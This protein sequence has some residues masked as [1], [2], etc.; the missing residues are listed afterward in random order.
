MARSAF[1]LAA[2]APFVALACFSSSTT[3]PGNDAAVTAPT[4][5]AATPDDATTS[6]EAAP[7]QEAAAAD[8]AAP[9][10]ATPDA[11]VLEAAAPD[12]A[13][14]AA[15]APSLTITATGL[16]GPEPGVVVVFGDSNGAPIATATTDATGRVTQPLTLDAM[17]ITQAAV[18]FGI[19]GLT[20]LEVVTFVGVEAGDTLTAIDTTVVPQFQASITPPPSPP[21]TPDGYA[22]YAGEC[23]AS[24]GLI[25]LG[26]GC[27]GQGTFPVLALSEYTTPLA[28][29][30]DK[31]DP[32]STDGGTASIM[33]AG[34]WFTNFGTQTISATGLTSAQFGYVTFSE[35][36][37]GVPYY[38]PATSS[39]GFAYG[40]DGGLSQATFD[41]HPG[42]P[43]FVQSEFGVQGPVAQS[44]AVATRGPAPTTATPSG[45]ASFD[46]SQLLPVI[47]TAQLSPSGGLTVTWT[48]GTPGSPDAGVDAGV[49]AGAPGIAGTF[50]QVNGTYA[51][52]GGVQAISWVFVAPPSA[53]TVSAPMLPAA[54]SPWTLPSTGS[55]T[56]DSYSPTIISVASNLL[57]GYPA[58]RQSSHLLGPA[59]LRN[60]A[61]GPTAVTPL[62][63]DG[64]LAA[65]VY[66]PSQVVP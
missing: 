41:T 34:P 9:E 51:T 19:P 25:S 58:L 52:E 57:P 28:F 37:G 32:L 40:A 24:P 4:P 29:A 53:T 63:F 48:P 33:M 61:G 18:L 47:P 49:D 1:A 5:E 23:S 13:V 6:P 15:P 22:I 59:L 45:S 44:T 17:T 56:F 62:P 55:G 3:P 35:V 12:V 54:A 20:P 39:S 10:A 66:I 11:T 2:L 8:G 38:A 14:E 36:A 16:M 26:V 43:D 60:A 50:V 31:A 30:F 7:P 42:Y 64:T 27:Y 21:G 65:T 46:T